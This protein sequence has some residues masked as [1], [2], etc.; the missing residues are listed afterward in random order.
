M[1][2]RRVDQGVVR[3]MGEVV[4]VL[5]RKTTGAMPRASA[6]WLAVDVAEAEDGGSGLV[7]AAPP[8]AVNGA[9]IDPSLSP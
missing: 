7:F 9:S 2:R 6:T 4:L 5:A 3:P 8:G 1:P